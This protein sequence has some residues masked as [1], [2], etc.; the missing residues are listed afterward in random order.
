VYRAGVR[1]RVAAGGIGPRAAVA[2]A[3]G[4]Y[5]ANYYSGTVTRLVAPPR[6]APLAAAGN[7]VKPDATQQQASLPWLEEK[8]AK[9]T[10]TIALGTQPAMDQMRQGEKLFSDATICFQGW[11][12]CASCHPD[13]RTDGLSWDLMNDGLGNPKSAKSMLLSGQTPPAMAHGIRASMQ[14]AVAAGYKFILF[15]VPTQEELDDTA[16]YIDS[17]RPARSPSRNPDGSLSAAAKR[18]RAIFERKD[19]ACATCHPAPLFTDLKSYDVGTRQ[20]FD[21]GGDLDT[22]TL[23]EVYRTGPYLHDGSAVSLDDVLKSRNHED[24]HGKT[25]QLSAA[26]LR[27]LV[28]YVLSL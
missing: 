26:E 7:D 1:Q 19:T 28:E 18:G 23:V 11:Q 15:H 13:G 21:S 20:S 22:P 6:T 25:S 4:A 16:T 14:V 24:H 3:D 9:V 5:V 8:T 12:S 10:Q 17:M 2:T 27:D